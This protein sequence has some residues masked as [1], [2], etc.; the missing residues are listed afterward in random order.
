MMESINGFAQ[1]AWTKTT[2]A[3]DYLSYDSMASYS[4]NAF[5]AV[6]G[7]VGSG[8]TTL[9][10]STVG[11]WTGFLKDE[12]I[13]GFNKVNT[14]AWN[15]AGNTASFSKANILPLVGVAG[16]GLVAFKALSSSSSDIQKGEYLK[17]GAKL[18]LGL[19]AAAFTAV[20]LKGIGTFMAE[21]NGL[22]NDNGFFNTPDGSNTAGS[23]SSNAGDTSAGGTSAGGTSAA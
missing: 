9:A 6:T 10:E 17:G 2:S 19:T 7:F 22:F 20:Q 14:A 8:Y 3:A 18:A 21:G 15:A 23:T 11:E 4:N 16:G 13:D 1:E 12:A 5:D